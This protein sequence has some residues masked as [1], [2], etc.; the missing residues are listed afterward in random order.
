[1]H[2]DLCDINSELR[3]QVRIERHKLSIAREKIARYIL[4]F[5]LPFFNCEIKTHTKNVFKCATIYVVYFFSTRN[6]KVSFPSTFYLLLRN[7][8]YI[9][10]RNLLKINIKLYN[11]KLWLI[12]PEKSKY[13]IFGQYLYKI[14]WPR[15]T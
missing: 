6:K 14:F 4:Q 5:W 2:S 15:Y 1:M 13:C 3:K 7:L 9:F 11:I 12:L 10:L 8:L